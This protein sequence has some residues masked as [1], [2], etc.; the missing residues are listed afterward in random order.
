MVEEKGN[1]YV[2]SV[3]G[4]DKDTPLT[5]LV[6]MSSTHTHMPFSYVSN[7]ESVHVQALNMLDVNVSQLATI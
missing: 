5:S 4:V 6:H 3:G 2:E 1:C 7:V